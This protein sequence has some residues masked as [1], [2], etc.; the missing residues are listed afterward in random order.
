MLSVIIAGV[1]YS[2][3]D[4]TLCHYIDDDGLGMAPVHRIAERGPEQHGDTDIDFR[5]D[6][7]IFK[8]VFEID[9][10]SASDLYNKR[11][12]LIGLFKPRR[13]APQLLWSL[14]NGNNRQIN[15]HYISDMNLPN[16]DRQS[17]SMPVVIT[18][19]ANDPTFYDPDIKSI[20]F[21]LGG[22]GDVGEI[23]MIVPMLVGVST[24]DASSIITY[25]GD[26]RSYPVIRIVGP[27]TD[28]VIEV[29]HGTTSETL[30]F[31]GT[32]IASSDYYDIDCRYGYKTVADAAGTNK[33][34]DLTSDSNLDTFHIEA[35]PD[36]PGGINTFHVT[37]TAI[38]AATTVG[39][40]YFE[41]SLGI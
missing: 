28:P 27:I 34:A 29:T 1:S 26:W 2:L 20:Y 25:S 17:Y 33:V 39:V 6:P 31:T 30:D 13:S 19:K 18:L 24:L 41:R 15:A 16:A 12:S 9:G 4:G 10:T 8:L 40:N 3:D 36:A 37:G 7:R 11:H 38:T 32:T 35:D 21:N 23:P 5:L 22:G 14:P